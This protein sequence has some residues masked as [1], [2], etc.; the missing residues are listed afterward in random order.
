MSTVTKHNEPALGQ[1]TEKPQFLFILKIIYGNSTFYS[2]ISKFC[3]I[4]FKIFP[5][6]IPRRLLIEKLKIIWSINF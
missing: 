3:I 2:K 6:K 1:N 4:F 5:Y